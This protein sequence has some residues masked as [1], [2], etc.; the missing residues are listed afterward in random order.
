[1]PLFEYECRDCGRTFEAFVTT[2]RTAGCPQCRSTSL[3]KLL[4]SP[5]M[6]GVGAGPQAKEHSRQAES[7]GAGG[8][9]CAC[10][11]NALN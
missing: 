9:G 3:T 11:A 7:C 10:R 5:G 2:E 8:A 1:M 4:S 6:V